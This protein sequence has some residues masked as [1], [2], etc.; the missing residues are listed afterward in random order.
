VV[1][2][3]NAPKNATSLKLDELIAQIPVEARSLP[4]QVGHFLK[5]V[6]AIT[7][8]H[9]EL[10]LRVAELEKQRDGGRHG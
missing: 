10:M 5:F 6:S 9:R 1:I 7:A 3:M 2:V 4:L 8:A